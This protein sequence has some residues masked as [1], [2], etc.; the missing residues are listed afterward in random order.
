M[1]IPDVL[2]TLTALP[3]AAAFDDGI[4]AGS[5]FSSLERAANTVLMIESSSRRG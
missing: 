2:K 4:V 1:V 3:P 5:S